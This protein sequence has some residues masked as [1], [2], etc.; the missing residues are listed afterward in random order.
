MDSPTP[1]TEHQ[2][3]AVYLLVNAGLIVVLA[4]AYGLGG[5]AAPGHGWG[6]G[7]PGPG[8]AKAKQAMASSRGPRAARVST[9]RGRPYPAGGL[10]DSRGR[11]GRPDRP[12][13]L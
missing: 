4:V 7:R 11:G 9:W 10:P 3:L 2:L 12:H 8:T 5:M 13:C 6:E 1:L